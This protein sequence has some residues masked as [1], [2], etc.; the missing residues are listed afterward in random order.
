ML[1]IALSVSLHTSAQAQDEEK[2]HEDLYK[3]YRLDTKVTGRAVLVKDFSDAAGAAGVGIGSAITAKQL[4]KIAEKYKTV[5]KMKPV[6]FDKGGPLGWISIL[7]GFETVK[8]EK[9]NPI[10]E[11][12]GNPSRLALFKKLSGGFYILTAIA[13]TVGTQRIAH[14]TIA[15]AK[16][17]QPYCGKNAMCE[18]PGL[19]S[20]IF[21]RGNGAAYEDQHQQLLDA[22]ATTAE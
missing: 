22:E 14:S 5:Y 17:N 9:G 16:Y 19:L 18:K 12:A 4:N 15:G 13:A 21:S 2:L 6:E 10:I 20:K 3:K 8:D 1:V 7:L 11:K